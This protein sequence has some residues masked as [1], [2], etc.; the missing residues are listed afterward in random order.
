M[1]F[2]Q[3]GVAALLGHRDSSLLCIFELGKRLPTLGD[4]LK[5]GIILRVP[6]EFLYPALYD[7]LRDEIRGQEESLGG[8][9]VPSLTRRGHDH[10]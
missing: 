10:T 5:L 6:I 7:R 4:A 9:T 8:S 1:G 2:R 3:K